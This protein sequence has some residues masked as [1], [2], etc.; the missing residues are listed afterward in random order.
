M[1]RN[2]IQDR[3]SRED[4]THKEKILKGFK[5]LS[6]DEMDKPLT[7]KQKEALSWQE[8][9]FRR[10]YHHGYNEG[11]ADANSFS[12]K[13]VC[14]FFN[15]KLTEWRYGD[16]SNHSFPPEIRSYLKEKK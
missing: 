3:V 2:L 10:G 6:G 13:K 5:L 4:Y 8:S 7:E 9:S 1:N 15:E 14:K 16:K 12:Y 11:S